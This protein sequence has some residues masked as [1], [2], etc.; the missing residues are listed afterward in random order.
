MSE[1]PN[2]HVSWQVRDAWLAK[3]P[4]NYSTQPFC[5]V[6]CPYYY[7]CYPDQFDDDQDDD[8]ERYQQT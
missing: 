7:E 3:P 6:D 8:D 5:H 1:I 2:Y 4:C